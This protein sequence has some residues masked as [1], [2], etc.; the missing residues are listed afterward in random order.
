MGMSSDVPALGLDRAAGTGHD[1]G[2]SRL[3]NAAA[4]PVTTDPECPHE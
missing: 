2:A 1:D 3:T 4:F